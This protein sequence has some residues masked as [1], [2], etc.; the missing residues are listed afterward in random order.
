MPDDPF[1]LE[2]FVIKQDE[3]VAGV[4]EY[5][6]ALS[7]LRDGQKRTHWIWF[8]FPQVAGLGRSELATRYAIGSADEARAYLAHPVLGPRLLEC[9][10]AILGADG[11][12]AT[13]ILGE[14]DD[15]KL[16][17]SMTLFAR[18]GGGRVFRDVLDRFFSGEEDERTI[19]RLT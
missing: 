2:R 19:E 7:E 13:E 6:R 3:E 18:V 17:S 14:P 16:R 9:C 5:D 15:L 4:T 10:D 11:D 8:V 12:S 1:D